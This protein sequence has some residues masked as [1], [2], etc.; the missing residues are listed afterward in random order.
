MAGYITGTL[1]LVIHVV[2]NTYYMTPP[3]R[4]D[5]LEEELKALKMD[6]QALQDLVPQALQVDPTSVDF[7]DLDDK[8]DEKRLYVHTPTQLDSLYLV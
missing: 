4:V 2:C 3:G 5:Q 8:Q 1:R 6:Q 7:D